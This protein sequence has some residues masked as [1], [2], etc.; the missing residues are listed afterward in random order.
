MKNT[1]ILLDTNVILD[2]LMAR[3]P[4]RKPAERIMKAC[5]SGEVNGCIAA[6]SV[7]NLF[8]ILRKTYTV[9]ERRD[10]L[11]TLCQ[12]APVIGI[13]G[14]TVERALRNSRFTDFEDCLQMECAKTAEAK[15][16]VTRNLEDF[17]ESDIEAILPEKFVEKAALR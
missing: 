17:Q 8:Y 13:D 4:F 15:F 11:I 10:I 5:I 16:I 2:Y 3:E 1:L 12:I 7:S 14:M 9:D 6:H